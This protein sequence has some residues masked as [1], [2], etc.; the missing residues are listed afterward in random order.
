[1]FQWPLDY[2]L[3]VVL[4]G[5]SMLGAACGMIGVFLLLRKRALVGDAISH[6]TLPGVCLAYLVGNA[7]G[8]EE[9]SLIWLL[10]GAAISGTIGA[11]AI[12]FLREWTR[13][14][15]DASLGIILSI[16]FGIGT[17]LLRMIQTLPHGNAAGLEGF[18]YGKTALMV[19]EDA[20]LIGLIALATCSIVAILQKEFA[21]LCFD[22][23]FARSQGWPVLALDLLLMACV[24]SVVI[25]GLQAVGLILVIALLIIPASASRLWTH[26]L[27]SMIWLSAFLGA[28]SGVAGAYASSRID[29]LPSGAAIVLVALL[30]FLVSLVW[31]KA[32][33]IWWR[34]RGAVIDRDRADVEHV[35]RGVYELLEAANANPSLAGMTRSQDVDPK[36]LDKL[37]H[38]SHRRLNQTINRLRN[39]E[40]IIGD[41]RDRIALTARGLRL[42]KES[43]RRHRLLELYF[44]RQ[45]ELTGE[46]VDRGADLI[47][48]DVDDQIMALLESEFGSDLGVPESFHPLPSDGLKL[49]AGLSQVAMESNAPSPNSSERNPNGTGSI[50]MERG[51]SR[52]DSQ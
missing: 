46:A 37:R 32:G 33:G 24:V 14:K 10:V 26:R 39:E 5:T 1:M 49:P 21:L 51:R 4:A 35:L 15:E 19:S 8:W 38:W 30:L 52:G 48:H 20:M 25:V 2:N 50:E 45:A 18:I 11:I 6:A 44:Q 28:I 22:A 27:N 29:R 40:A 3:R 13:L 23:S 42:A 31:G 7:L 43:V 17:A 41:N 9:K 36:A 47:E 34:F 12:V 16:F